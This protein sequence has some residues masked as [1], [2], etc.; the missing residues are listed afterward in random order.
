MMAA[1]P[2]PILADDAE[3]VDVAV[4]RPQPIDELNA[5][6]ER[7]LGTPHEFG[8]V[9]LHE[10]VVLLDRGDGRLADADRANRLAFDQLN[11]IQALEQLPEERGGHPA[12]STAA[13]NEDL[14]HCAGRLTTLRRAGHVSLRFRE[15]AQPG[16]ARKRQA[17]AAAELEAA[18]LREA[19][20]SRPVE[21]QATGELVA[22]AEQH[23][24]QTEAFCAWQPSSDERV[25]PVDQVVRSNG[26][27]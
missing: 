2:F 3:A 23:V 7:G 18:V 24:R 1:Q 20:A 12:R 14:A 9:Q 8:L 5:E 22:A 16:F 6:L 27:A 10:L 4:A 11:V 15:L 19:I 25:R 13:N 21:G 17:V 26:A